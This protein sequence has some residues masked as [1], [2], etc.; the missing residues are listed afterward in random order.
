MAKQKR[1]WFIIFELKNYGKIKAYSYREA[2]DILFRAIFKGKYPS[3][4]VLIEALDG[5]EVSDD[6]IIAND[7]P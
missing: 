3:Y 6:D 1:T 5:E 7:S 4:V 2:E